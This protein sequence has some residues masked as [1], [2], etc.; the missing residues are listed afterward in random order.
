MSLTP[1]QVWQILDEVKDP[2]IPVVSVVEMGIIR[3]VEVQDDSVRVTMT[4]T[5]SGCPALEVMRREIAERLSQA[6]VKEVDVRLAINQPW[7]S[8]WI[9]PEARAK[10]KQFGLAPPALH[11]GNIDL[12]S[13]EPVACPY[14]GSTNTRMKNPFGSTLCRAIYYCDQCKQP[15]EKFKPI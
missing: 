12:A 13:Q 3:Q 6:G 10:L 15:F 9:S 1:E 14:C 5:F 8:D 4:P 7:S 11:H 2:E